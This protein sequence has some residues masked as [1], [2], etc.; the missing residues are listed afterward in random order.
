MDIPAKGRM[1]MMTDPAGDFYG[2]W[3]PAGHEGFA[4]F[5][6]AGA[7][8]YHQLTTR[9][10]A[11]ALDFYRTVF[12]WSTEVV[13]DTAEFRYSTASFDGEALVGVMDGSAFIPE[14]VP[15]AWTTFFG[16]EDVDKTIEVIAAVLSL[17]RKSDNNADYR[18]TVLFS[19]L[20]RRVQV[21]TADEVSNFAR[22]R[23]V[24]KAIRL[25]LPDMKPKRC[26]FP[27]LPRLWQKSPKRGID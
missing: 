18:Y 21:S 12:G 14:G 6:E 9:D 13:S 3:Q 24:P 1:A 5:N 19:F 27:P 10:Y 2:I 4:L 16:A 17:S 23:V 7:P 8:A 26:T 25:P 11:G 22:H 15:G 20:S